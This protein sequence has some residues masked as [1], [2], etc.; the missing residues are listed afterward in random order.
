MAPVISALFKQ[1]LV[2]CYENGGDFLNLAKS[3]GIKA[4][5]A[6]KIVLRHKKGLASRKHGGYKN[7]NGK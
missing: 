6:R 3:L 7:R 1:K 5:T 4:D 2:E